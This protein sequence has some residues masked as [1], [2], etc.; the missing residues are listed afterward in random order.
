MRKHHQ[1]GNQGN[2]NRREMKDIKTIEIR[3]PTT[4]EDKICEAIT[5]DYNETPKM[6]RQVT[7]MTDSKENFIF[8]VI[9]VKFSIH[10]RENL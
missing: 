8:N 7:F 1:K 3:E 5:R 9:C 6:K 10:N 4:D 2:F